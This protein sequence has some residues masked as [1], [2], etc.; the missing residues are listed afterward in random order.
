VSREQCLALKNIAAVIDL[1]GR[2]GI[3]PEGSSITPVE[4]P[5]ELSADD[6]LKFAQRDFEE[7]STRGDVNAMGNAKRALHA[8]IDAI[9]F[10]TGFWERAQ[11]KRWNF[12]SKAELLAEIYV[13]AP[14]VLRRVN[15]LRNT[16]EHEYSAPAN[17][18]RLE[19]FI[20]SIVLFLYGTMRSATHRYED[21]SFDLPDDGGLGISFDGSS[22]L[23]VLYYGQDPPKRPVTTSNFEEFRVLQAAVYGAARRCGEFL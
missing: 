2:E 6:Y 20:D 22:A 13:V 11:S 10:T 18:D 12:D 16:V 23:E 21:V 8:R 19:D 4:L 1:L 14:G 7:E 17:R 15:Q 9:L 5:W 3:E